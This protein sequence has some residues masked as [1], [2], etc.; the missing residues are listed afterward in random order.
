MDSN[1][2]FFLIVGVLLMVFI[3]GV[4]PEPPRYQVAHGQS[5]AIILDT[6][7]GETWASDSK[8]YGYEVETPFLFPLRYEVK[9]ADNDYTAYTPEETRNGS[10]SKWWTYIKGKFKKSR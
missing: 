5:H 1:S 9:Q 7:T 8:K 6:K 2:I 3:S 10:N 4:H